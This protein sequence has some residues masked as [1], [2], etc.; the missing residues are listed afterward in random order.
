MP[1]IWSTVPVLAC[2]SFC[3]KKYIF[4]INVRLG[5]LE[6]ETT[7][8]TIFAKYKYNSLS[9]EEIEF[10]K[11][12]HRS[13]Q[14]KAAQV[15]AFYFDMSFVL[16]NKKYFWLTSDQARN[17]NFVKYKYNRL[18]TEEGDRIWRKGVLTSRGRTH[19]SSIRFTF[20]GT[21]F[22]MIVYIS[23]FL[24]SYFSYLSML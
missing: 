7:Q 11:K 24:W 18:L 23:Y 3:T 20:V 1:S 15:D 13:V 21:W 5:S 6:R 17:T 2:H 8:K 14:N 12:M 10:E 22:L 4:L 19:C 16:C 9:T